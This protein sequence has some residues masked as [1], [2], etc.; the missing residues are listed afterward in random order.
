MFA[1]MQMKLVEDGRNINALPAR[2]WGFG[3][4]KRGRQT[5]GEG[6][7]ERKVEMLPGGPPHSGY[8]IRG[9]GG[10]RGRGEH[11]SWDQSS[12]GKEKKKK[13]VSQ[14]FSVL[15]QPIKSVMF[16]VIFKHRNEANWLW[17]RRQRT[18]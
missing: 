2:P 9:G 15:K 17:A 14:S 13:K 18:P 3:E 5:Q 7:N 16:C 11:S 8:Y 12:R 4:E 10:R 1:S 6:R